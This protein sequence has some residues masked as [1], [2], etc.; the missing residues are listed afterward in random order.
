MSFGRLT[1]Q[2]RQRRHNGGAENNRRDPLKI[3]GRDKT[4]KYASI[5]RLVPNF[6]ASMIWL[7]NPSTLAKT[8][9]PETVTM[10]LNIRKSDVRAL[11]SIIPNRESALGNPNGLGLVI[12]A[13]L[14]Y[15]DTQIVRGLE[16]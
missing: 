4:P 2:I 10:S 7:R 12:L 13:P 9:N 11:P 16:R 5:S 6:A 15:L 14:K 1:L 3:E 8:D